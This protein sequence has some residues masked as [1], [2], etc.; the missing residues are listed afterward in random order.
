MIPYQFNLLVSVLNSIRLDSASGKNLSEGERSMLG[1]Y[2]EAAK[3][4]KNEEDGVLVPFYRFYDDPVKHLGKD[5]GH[6]N[7]EYC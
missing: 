4:V 1:A 5:T 6:G 2:Q 7:R 3:S